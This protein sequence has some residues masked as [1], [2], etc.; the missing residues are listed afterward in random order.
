MKSM[1]SRIVD[2]L[3]YSAPMWIII[4][5]IYTI[6]G[7]IIGLTAYLGGLVFHRSPDPI[8]IVIGGVVGLVAGLLKLLGMKY[9]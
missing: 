4:C 6:G 2:A 8:F 7:A 9:K 1:L 5:V 3:L